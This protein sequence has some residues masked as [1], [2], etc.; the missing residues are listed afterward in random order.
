M[1]YETLIYETDD[2]IARICFNRPE[3]MN[4]FSLKMMDEVKRA[5][6]EADANPAVRVVIVQGVGGKAFST[7]YDIKES[8]EQPERT[9]S[10]WRKR[11]RDDVGF[12]YAPWDCRK[13]VIAI[14]DGY[15]VGGGLE[16]AL[17][18]DIRYASPEARFGVVEA[19]FAT[20]L[21]TLMMPWV[22]GN[23]CRKLIYTGDEFGADEA[24]RIGLIDEV[25]E[26]DELEAAVTKIARRMSRVAMEY[27][28]LNKQA[29]NETFEIMGLRSALNN[30]AHI[31][32]AVSSS[33]PPEFQEYHRI[34]RTQGLK[35][36]LKWRAAQFRPYE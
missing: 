30:G 14:I 33:N 4:A 1:S 32:A 12:T 28:I 19:R 35:E 11:V 24:R 18:C 26:K 17:C 13:P 9:A 23:Y 34:R 5:F 25:F 8:A 21:S 6:A 22:V 2:R 36:A 10:D 31:A 7:G 27:L 20:G 16:F 15:C 29:I 3:R